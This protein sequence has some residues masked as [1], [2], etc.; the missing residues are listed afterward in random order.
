MNV[1]WHPF[2]Y[3]NKRATAPSSDSIVWIVEG[4]DD[5]T[6]GYFDGFTFRLWSG[7]DD[8]DITHWAIIEYPEAPE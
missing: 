6:L 1:Q 2:D 4:G 5:V 8:C 3:E 7:T